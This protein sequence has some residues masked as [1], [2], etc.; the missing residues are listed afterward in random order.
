MQ[1]WRQFRQSALG[2]KSHLAIS[3]F[4]GERRHAPEQDVLDRGGHAV[5]E[6]ALVLQ[7]YSGEFRRGLEE[8]LEGE[9]VV[10]APSGPMRDYEPIMTVDVERDEVDCRSVVLRLIRDSWTPIG[11]RPE[12]HVIS[13]T[14]GAGAEADKRCKINTKQQTTLKYISSSL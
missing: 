14:K 5:V 6:E 2:E 12:D 9:T 13:E 4:V 1:V 3:V 7:P 11:W 10:E 8:E